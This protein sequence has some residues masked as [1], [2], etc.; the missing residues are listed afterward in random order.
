MTMRRSW[1]DDMRELFGMV[2]R[3][4][5]SKTFDR[6]PR[7]VRARTWD[8]VAMRGTPTGWAFAY[9][10]TRALRNAVWFVRR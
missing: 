8:A 6:L 3:E 2:P 7:G 5:A 10:V 9:A 1:L 4:I